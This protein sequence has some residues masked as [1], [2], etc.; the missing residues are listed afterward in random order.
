[1]DALVEAHDE[2]EL[3]QALECGARLV[4]VNNRNL[5]TLDVSLEVT[6][7]TRVASACGR[8]PDR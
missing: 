6:E 5:K 2:A 3:D 7:S 1:M 4:G 8:D